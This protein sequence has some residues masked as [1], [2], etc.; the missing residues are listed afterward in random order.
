MDKKTEIE[1][2]ILKCKHENFSVMKAAQ[3][4]LDLFHK[5]IIYQEWGGPGM[6]A[7]VFTSKGKWESIGDLF[8]DNK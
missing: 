6:T 2:Y 8:K 5:E 1:R 4:I 7:K 3:L